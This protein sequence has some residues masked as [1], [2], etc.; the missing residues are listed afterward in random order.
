MLDRCIRWRAAKLTENKEE[1]TLVKA[2]DVLWMSIHGPPKELIAGSE[3]GLVL[4]EKDA[5]VLCT[6]RSQAAPPRKG[7][8]C[9]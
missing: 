6:R 8:A 1:D 9:Q 7:T 4:S 3:S 2:I 5:G